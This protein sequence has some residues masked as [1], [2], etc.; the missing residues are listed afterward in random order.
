MER[1][2][3]AFTENAQQ[4]K[5]LLDDLQRKLDEVGQLYL[6]FLQIYNICGSCMSSSVWIENDNVV[7]SMIGYRTYASS[8]YH[9]LPKCLVDMMKCF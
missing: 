7:I 8:F 6:L 4:M 3:A 9:V 2:K 5:R 1:R